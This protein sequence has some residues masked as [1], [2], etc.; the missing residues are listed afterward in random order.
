MESCPICFQKH[1]LPKRDECTHQICFKCLADWY[2]QSTILTCP[3]CRETS[4]FFEKIE[5]MLDMI[6]L[7]VKELTEIEKISLPILL[8]F[9]NVYVVGNKYEKIWNSKDMEIYRKPVKQL[10]INCFTEED[11]DNMSYDEYM[12]FEKL[13]NF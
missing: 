10:C 8:S 12:I 5:N 4:H 13:I 2:D 7:R 3:L 11:V 6:L 9:V 1:L